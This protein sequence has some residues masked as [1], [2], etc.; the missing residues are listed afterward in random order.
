MFRNYPYGKLPLS[1]RNRDRKLRR[2]IG[3]TMD[4][5]LKLDLICFYEKKGIA[6]LIDELLSE[7][8]ESEEKE[9]MESVDTK[10]ARLRCSNVFRKLVKIKVPGAKR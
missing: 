6:D 1:K 7:R 3:F 2:L 9:I 10:L 5:F 8:W 4:A